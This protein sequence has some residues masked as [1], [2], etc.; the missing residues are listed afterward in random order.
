P[1]QRRG[2]GRRARAPGREGLLQSVLETVGG[3]V[4]P[5]QLGIIGAGNMA[6]ALARGWREPV[7]VSDSGS[8]SG[9]A[10]AL[11]AEVGGEALAS[12][13][14][15]AER[16]ELVVLCHKPAQ[17][18]L[19]AGEIAPAARALLSVLGGVNMAALQ[20]AYAATPP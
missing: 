9:R 15:V 6:R 20:E 5:M 10:Q 16:A 1:A 11:A 19:V 14:A 12:N 7:L 3:N 18:H 8:G 2:L 4:P 13:L 17:P